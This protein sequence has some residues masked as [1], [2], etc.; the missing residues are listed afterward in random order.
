[1]HK[2]PINIFIDLDET[3]IHT[4]G[5][6]PYTAPKGKDSTVELK[7]KEPEPNTDYADTPVKIKLDKEVYHYHTILRP[8]ANFLLFQLRE[9]GHVYML[10][11]AA[12]SYAQAMNQAFNFGFIEDKIFDREYVKYWKYKAPKVRIA[13]GKNFLIDDLNV[14]DN[15]EKIAFIKKYGTVEYIKVKEFDGYK[16]NG[17]TQSDLTDIINTIKS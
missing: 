4:L 17:L 11:R 1:M 14:Q 12:K 16:G 10:T 13:T 5:M 8:G 15:F 2:E 6:V 3:L 9:I 7:F